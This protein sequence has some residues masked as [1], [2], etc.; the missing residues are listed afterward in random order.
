M[1][2][3]KH[4]FGVRKNSIVSF[5]NVL[6]V[7]KGNVIVTGEEELLPTIVGE[8]V[9]VDYKKNAI[10]AER[11]GFV[12]IS[13]G[14]VYIDKL[15][16][17]PKNIDHRADIKNFTGSLWVQGDI[18]NGA[19]LF[20]DGNL[21]IDGVVE[22][23]NIHCVGDIIINGHFYGQESAKIKA[24]GNISIGEI[25]SGEVSAKN[26]FV[27]EL[28]RFAK[29]V[30][31]DSI[32]VFGKGEIMGGKTFAKNEIKAKVLGGKNLPRTEIYIGYDFELKF[33]LDNLK[34]NL[35]KNNVK[36]LINLE[37]LT[38]FLPDKSDFFENDYINFIMN[39]LENLEDKKHYIFKAL[40]NIKLLEEKR[41]LER[42]IKKFPF[43]NFTSLNAKL[44]TDKIFPGVTIFVLD[45]KSEI[46]EIIE[47]KVVI[48]RDGI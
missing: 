3:K 34:K 21:Q 14:K 30:A 12:R 4:I 40:E 5:E 10:I 18:L 1:I 17:I 7:E 28:V 15:T 23:C 45:K 47:K 27:N 37:S 31:K 41:N 39:G 24:R 22:N 35:E 44:K 26:I 25:H 2:S 29:I 42:T 19:E 33:Y 38:K 32:Y 6:P 13:Q 43:K 36:L 20:V 46:T 9:S 16:I 11:D 48:G 8:G